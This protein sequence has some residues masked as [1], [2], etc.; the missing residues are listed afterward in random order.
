VT[1]SK[2]VHGETHQHVKACLV[3]GLSN[4]EICERLHLSRS[5][6]NYH[7]RNFYAEHGLSNR[8]DVRRLI[9]LLVREQPRSCE[10]SE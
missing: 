1:R 8:A 7:M 10:K 3:E 5:G 9:V 6:L 2:L 4:K